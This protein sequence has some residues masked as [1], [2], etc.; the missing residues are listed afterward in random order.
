MSSL[1]S[2]LPTR[3]RTPV[4]PLSKK[5]EHIILD[6]RQG[7]SPREIFT[8]GIWEM[9]E[10]DY[11]TMVQM[12][13]KYCRD[14]LRKQGIAAEV[15]GRAKSSDSIKKSLERREEHRM[16]HQRKKYQNLGEIFDDIHDLA[17]VRIVVQ[18]PADRDEATRFIRKTFRQ[19]K[20]PNIFTSDREVDRLWKAWFGA[21]Q[22]WNHRVSLKPDA[23]VDLQTYHSVMFEIQLTTLPERLYNK[24]AHPLLYKKSSGDLSRKDEMVIDLSHGLALCYSLCVSYM[25]DKLGP[26]K[27]L[28][29]QKRLCDTL[30][31]VMPTP[32]SASSEV[33]MDALADMVPDIASGSNLKSLASFGETIPVE[34]LL[35][36]LQTPPRGCCST[37]DVWEQMINKL[38]YVRP[39]LLIYNVLL[40][41]SPPGM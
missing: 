1:S 19:M 14:Q 12:L 9:L 5:I 40:L 35:R 10:N 37:E 3:S 28:G 30:R 41:T 39:H 8:N 29:E 26:S 25:Q 27:G 13:V 15:D 34:G 32:G 2:T 16:R 23:P 18:Y 7:K 21:Y 17:G 24:L 33:D 11:E 38:G 4:T 31:K 22:S 20:E 36:A 6:K